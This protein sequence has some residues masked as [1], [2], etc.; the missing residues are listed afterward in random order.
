MNRPIDIECKKGVKI[1]EN[2]LKKYTLM[3]RT[4]LVNENNT[5]LA[6][7]MLWKNNIEKEF[8]GVEECAICYYV[9]HS[10][11][12]DLPKLACKTCKHKFHSVC[13]HKWFDSSNKSE[14]P[15]CK[16]QFW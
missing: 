12:K 6:A 3:M 1:P 9:V 13:I 4:I 14:C 15:L 11:T 7:L 2:K 8:E 5:F 10:S 16:S